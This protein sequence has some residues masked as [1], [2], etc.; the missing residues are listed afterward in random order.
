MSLNIL[1]PSSTENHKCT[2]YLSGHMTTQTVGVS[3]PGHIE[4]LS[5]R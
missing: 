5:E 2:V 4:E 1:S 3:L